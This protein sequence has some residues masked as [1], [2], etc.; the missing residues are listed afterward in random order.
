MGYRHP[1]E[2]SGHY[3]MMR[4]IKPSC[5]KCSLLRRCYGQLCVAPQDTQ[6]QLALEWSVS[7]SRT[8][9]ACTEAQSK[10]SMVT[11]FIE[12]CPFMIIA[13]MKAFF[14]YHGIWISLDKSRTKVKTMSVLNRVLEAG[15]FLGSCHLSKLTAWIFTVAELFGLG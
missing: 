5:L 15:I 13:A 8:W 11:V 6:A 1:I 14:F 9:C 10:S 7:N 4:Q 12:K 3:W 2:H